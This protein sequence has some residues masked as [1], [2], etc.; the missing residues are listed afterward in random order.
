MQKVGFK[1]NDHREILGGEKMTHRGRK[2]EDKMKDLINEFI[3]NDDVLNDLG[4]LKKAY[5][6]I[7]LFKWLSTD[8]KIRFKIHRDVERY[9]HREDVLEELRQREIENVNDETIEDITTMFEDYLDNYSNWRECLNIARDC[10]D[11]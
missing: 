8:Y 5:I 10:H 1:K 11:L 4:N 7:A 6:S 3:K 9:W 2:L